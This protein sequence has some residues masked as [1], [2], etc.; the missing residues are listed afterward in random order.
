MY[1]EILSYWADLIKV[2]PV[3]KNSSRTIREL[4][5]DKIRDAILKGHLRPGEKISEPQWAQKL[6]V[7]RTPLREAIRCLGSEGFLT[8]IP[9]KG[10]VVS[11][12][13]EKDVRDFYEVKGLL[14]GYAAR[15]ACG[16]M[17]PAQV[18]RM[19]QINDEMDRSRKVSH[20]R[21]L[22]NLH[23]EFH[24]IFLTACENHKLYQI[25]NQ[26]IQQFQRFRIALT[27]SGRMEGSISQH[28]DIITAFR[29]RDADRVEKLV[30]E[31]AAF[32]GAIIIQEILSKL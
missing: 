2:K 14:E 5:A 31:N 12:M 32:G 9:R 23:N 7:S 10:A 6:K 13:T 4:I 17:V 20:W 1:F 16:K 19:E 22:F 8:V 26:L 28:R 25:V 11:P 24:D 27:M 18:D 21:L 30:R 29:N 15:L 3:N